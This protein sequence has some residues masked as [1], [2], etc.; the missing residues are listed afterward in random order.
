VSWKFENYRNAQLLGGATFGAYEDE[1][2]A[3]GVLEVRLDILTEEDYDGDAWEG[4][5]GRDYRFV[6]YDRVRIFRV[7]VFRCVLFKIS[8]GSVRCAGVL[9]CLIFGVLVYH[10]ALSLLKEAVGGLY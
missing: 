1:L 4:G 5:I 10:K 3:N 7:V 9:V 6:I 8:P 2:Y